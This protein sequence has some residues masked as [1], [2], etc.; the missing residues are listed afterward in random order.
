MLNKNLYLDEAKDLE[1]DNKLEELI[2]LANIVHK[3]NSRV[4]LYKLVRKH[5]T[6]K[7]WCCRY[8]FS[9]TN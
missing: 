4:L 9:V 6:Q 5:K 3:K 8:R 7:N 1:Q 2:E